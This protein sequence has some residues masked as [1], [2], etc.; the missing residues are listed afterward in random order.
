MTTKSLRSG[1]LSFGEE[2]LVVSRKEVGTQ[3]LWSWFYV[4][5]FLAK[6]Y[7]ETIT[8]MGRFSSNTFLR[9]ISIQVRNLGKGIITFM[10][11][12]K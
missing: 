12:K 8:I 5:L 6:V 4:E 3:S 11:N 1:T 2:R 9:C 7:P 10:T